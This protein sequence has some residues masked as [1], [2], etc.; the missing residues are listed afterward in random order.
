MNFHSRLSRIASA[1]DDDS[2]SHAAVIL[3]DPIDY[4]DYFYNQHHHY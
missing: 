4:D 3:A 2:C 1:E